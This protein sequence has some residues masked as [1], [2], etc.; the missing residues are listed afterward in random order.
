MKKIIFVLISFLFFFLS[1]SKA[2]E[3]LS[4]TG[5]IVLAGNKPFTYICF[6]SEDGKEYAVSAESNVI[7]EITDNSDKR[8]IISGELILPSKNVKNHSGK[9]GTVI[10]ESW[11]VVE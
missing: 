3:K 8:I 1:F 2:P 7:S 4:A 9:D 10:V 5:S 6:L 11:K